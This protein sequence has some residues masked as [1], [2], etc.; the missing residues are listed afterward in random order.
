MVE[1]ISALRTLE[2]LP[3]DVKTFAMRAVNYA[4]KRARTQASDKIREQ[5]NFKASYLS[6]REGRLTIGRPATKANLESKITGRFQPTSLARF[7]VGNPTVGKPGVRVSVAPGFA[8][9]MKRAFVIN[10]P[11]GKTLDVAGGVLNRGLAIRL[12]PGERIERKYRQVQLKGGLALLYGVSVDQL[13]STI[14]PEMIPDIEDW[15]NNEFGRQ[16]AQRNAGNIF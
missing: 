2:T 8:R 13:L 5:V 14:G 16:V 3:D 9:M 12:K 7:I 15:L 1:G 4:T 6:E 10:L 11:Q